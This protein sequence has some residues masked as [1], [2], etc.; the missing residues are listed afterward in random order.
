M[1]FIESL[2][3]IPRHVIFLTIAL[4][5]AIPLIIPI[6]IPVNIMPQTKKLFEA[7]E[8]LSPESKPVLISCDFDPQSLPELYPMLLALL[9]QCF[10][11]NVPVP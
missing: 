7:V 5:I 2:T 3:K 10:S 1:K 8:D 11:K 4:A 9:R 6:G